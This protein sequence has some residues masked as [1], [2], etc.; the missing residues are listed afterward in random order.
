M[1]EAVALTLGEAAEVIQVRLMNGWRP[2][3]GRRN[4]E[5]LDSVSGVSFAWSQENAS[6]WRFVFSIRRFGTWRKVEKLI[7][8]TEDAD[9]LDQNIKMATFDILNE[10][11]ETIFDD[12]VDET[13]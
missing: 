1:D 11:F 9:E 10:M 8:I 5:E 6:S 3:V 7:V 13:D 2:R 4:R 12:C